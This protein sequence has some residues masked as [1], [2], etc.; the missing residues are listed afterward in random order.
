MFLSPN[1][2]SMK[3]PLKEP[4]TWIIFVLIFCVLSYASLPLSFVRFSLTISVMLKNIL[5]FFIPFLIFSGTASALSAFKGN[6]VQ[7]V[8]T[9]M[10]IIIMSNFCN[11]MF[12]GLIGYYLI[13]L[14][15]VAG[16]SI[17]LVDTQCSIKPFFTFQLPCLLPNTWALIGG[18]AVG[19]LTSCFHWSKVQRGVKSLHKL[20]MQCMLK[21]FIP[22]LPFFLMGFILKLLLEGQMFYFVATNA[23]SCV[24]M[25]V[26]LFLYLSLWLVMA[27]RC[28]RMPLGLI[29]RNI[30]PAMM[31]G[32]ST[33]SSAAALPFSIEAAT[34]NT[35][36]PVLANAVMPI[37]LN[38]HMVGDTICIPIL[39][40]IIMNTFSYPMP[41]FLTLITFGFCFVLNKCAG[42]G[43]PGGTI[44]VSL[45]ILQN[46]F[47]FS[48]EMLALIT[49]F[50][51]LIDPMTTLGNVTANNLLVVFINRCW[52]H[53]KRRAASKA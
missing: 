20:V 11:V 53:K 17:P 21:G 6:G 30:F 49:A 52:G 35:K 46:Y 45:P 43:I 2:M 51:M 28:S 5:L 4:I 3:R 29:L 48:E 34:K 14:T 41:D 33:M 39:A 26:V 25:I 40:M 42:A 31:T 36:D 23:K 8:V 32:A 7:F 50:Y 22:L 1:I 10:T 12:S 24:L 27:G 15:S 16:Q 38:F 19:I 9:M 18:L 13:P 47:G 37:S 44:M